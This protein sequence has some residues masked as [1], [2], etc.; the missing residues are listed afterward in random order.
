MARVARMHVEQRT[1]HMERTQ[2]IETLNNNKA[3][4][5]SDYNE[6]MSSYK[7][8][9]TAKL[10][11]AYQKALQDLPQ[12]YEKKKAE[13]ADLS[14][15][16]IK[17]QTRWFQLLP[18]I[19][20]E[21]PVPVSYEDHYDMAISIFSRDVRSVVELSYAEFCCFVRNEWDWSSD[22]AATAQFYKSAAV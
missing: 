2:L 5:V 19:S 22:F 13:I 3:R 15:A 21:M 20:V 11:A 6:A 17:E 16:G 1:V 4:H 8:V 7:E 12:A 14:D 9:L 18:T 10:E